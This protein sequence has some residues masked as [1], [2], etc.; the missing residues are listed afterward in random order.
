MKKTILNLAIVAGVVAIVLGGTYAAWTAS[1]TIEGNTLS[2]A[3]VSLGQTGNI[4]KP[5]EG[6]NMIPGEYTEPARAG[7]Y[8]TGTVPLRIYMHT[9]NLSDDSTGGICDYTLLSL[10]TGHAN[11]SPSVD[12]DGRIIDGQ[13]NEAERYIE[14][15]SVL[16]WATQEELT[17]IPPFNELGANITQIIWQQAQLDPDAPQHLQG[18][19]CTWDEVFTGETL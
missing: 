19:T 3:T 6:D 15:K 14:T 1:T 16:D 4:E 8:N 7:I 18:Q 5:I 17:G 10:Y 2:T 13:N 9:D 11:G 12:G